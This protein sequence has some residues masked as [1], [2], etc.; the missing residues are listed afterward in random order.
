MSTQTTSGQ[1]FPAP[2]KRCGGLLYQPADL[3]PYCGARRPLA[4]PS[5]L[6]F[7]GAHGVRH[8]PIQTDAELK[9]AAPELASPKASIPRLDHLPLGAPVGSR[10]LLTRGL[11]ALVVLM[12]GYGVYTLFGDHRTVP[13]AYDAQDTKSTAGSIAPYSPEQ[14]A[15]SPANAGAVNASVAPRQAAPAPVVPH[16]RDLSESLRAA[17]AHEDAHDLS[18]AQAAVNA[19]L[20]MD[21]GNAD[22]LQIQHEITPLEQRRD[23][24]LQT[25]HVCIKDRLWNCVEHSASDALAVDSGSP[26]AKT[27]LQQAI[28]ETGWAPLGSHA[29]RAAKTAQLPSQAPRPAQSAQTAPVVT[30]PQAAPAPNSIDAQERAIAQSGWRATPASAA[31]PAH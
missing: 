29:A 7:A 20:S 3:C 23:A 15:N 1:S 14:T 24:A 4:T 28:V 11:I 31:A 9:S 10:W 19:A 16:Y 26:E 21:S 6:R 12:L 5:H 18:G 2:C 13:P 17:H 8:S 22:A 30:A 25:A 27:L